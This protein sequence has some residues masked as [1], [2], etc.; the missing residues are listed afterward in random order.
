MITVVLKPM[1]VPLTRAQESS[2]WVYLDQMQ[3]YDMTTCPT[4]LCLPLRAGALAANCA[5][6]GWRDASTLT[7]TSR[8]AQIAV[9][10]GV[11][12]A[13]IDPLTPKYMSLTRFED[14]H[15][16]DETPLK[17]CLRAEIQILVGHHIQ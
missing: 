16:V 12:P 14:N 13:A 15:E 1:C 10:G 11:V 4:V 7:P 5:R 2:P 8:I 3:T 6:D 9:S 17:H